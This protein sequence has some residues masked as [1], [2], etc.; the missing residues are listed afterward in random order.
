MISRRR[1]LRS[2]ASVAVVSAGAIAITATPSV[3]AVPADPLLDLINRYKAEEAR[4][5][6]TPHG[7]DE[8]ADADAVFLDELYHQLE[9]WT[10]PATTET[11]ALAALRLTHDFL[12]H[13]IG[14]YEGAMNAAA[15][16]YFEGRA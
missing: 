7:S 1:F 16:G 14:G 9:D 8:E 10:E 2:S 3:A 12:Q 5:N 6:A 4:F 15:L 13:S 11:G